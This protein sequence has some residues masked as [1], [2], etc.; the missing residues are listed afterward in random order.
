MNRRQFLTGLLAAAP[1]A[2]L[3]PSR[4]IFLPPVGG[5]PVDDYFS[6]PWPNTLAPRI[7]PFTNDLAHNFNTDIDQLLRVVWDTYALKPE[8]LYVSPLEAQRV[9]YTLEELQ[10]RIEA[11]A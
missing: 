1:A 8:M 9:G 11:V 2:L 10:Q 6:L 5:W 7:T 3:V 4:T